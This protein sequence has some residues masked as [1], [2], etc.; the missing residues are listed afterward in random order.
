MV[1]NTRGDSEVTKPENVRVST[2]DARP[3]LEAYWSPEELA[4]QLKISV[5]TLNRWHAM[6]RGPPRITQGRL[7]LYRVAAVQQWLASREQ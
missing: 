3:F 2:E 6:R 1:S 5:R 4:R 7:V